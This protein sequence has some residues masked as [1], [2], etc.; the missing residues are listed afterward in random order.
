M[1]M[2]VVVMMMMLM[3]ATTT[4]AGC[5]VTFDAFDLLVRVD[6][7][8]EVVAQRA[9]LQRLRVNI[10]EKDYWRRWK[11]GHLAESV[12]VAKVEEIE[13]SVDPTAPKC[14]IFHPRNSRRQHAHSDLLVL[15]VVPYHVRHQKIHNITAL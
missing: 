15:L 14:H 5:H 8:D 3:T 6:S 12:G 13:A 1:M 7:N 9:R 11:K 2:M 4:E 10:A